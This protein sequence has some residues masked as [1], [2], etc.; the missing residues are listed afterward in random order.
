MPRYYL[1]TSAFAK[2][3]RTEPGTPVVD[4]IMEDE[5]AQ[6]FV[7]RL[8]ITELCSVFMTRVRTGTLDEHDISVIQSL[9]IADLKSS[10]F[11]TLQVQT[12]HFE[13]AEQLL[14]QHGVTYGLRTLDSLQLAV[15][16]DVHRRYT[17]DFFV[18]AD[19]KLLGIAARLGLNV[20]DPEN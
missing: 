8:A 9:V 2:R 11:A 7:S 10:R 17:L 13:L 4:R 14:T 12:Q 1:D 6:R 18:A 20:I 16:L 15:A 19:R 3:Y 5:A